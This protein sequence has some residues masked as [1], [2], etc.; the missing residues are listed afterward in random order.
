MEPILQSVVRE[1][2]GAGQWTRD[3]DQMMGAIAREVEEQLAAVTKE[4]EQRTAERDEANGWTKVM[5]D[6][7]RLAE[8]NDKI[9]RA[10]W[11]EAEEKARDLAAKLADA[12]ACAEA[13][14]ASWRRE[15]D[16]LRAEIASLKERLA[17][18][19]AQCYRLTDAFNANESENDK[20]KAALGEARELLR[21]VAERLDWELDGFARDR[22]VAVKAC[23]EAFDYLARPAPES[24]QKPAEQRRTEALAFFASAPTFPAGMLAIPGVHM[25]GSNHSQV[26]DSP[27]ESGDHMRA[28]QAKQERKCSHCEK[29]H[30]SRLACPEYAAKQEPAPEW[31]KT[32]G[33][34]GFWREHTSACHPD[35]GC[36]SDCPEQIQCPDCHGAGRAEESPESKL[37]TPAATESGPI[38]DTQGRDSCGI[39]G[40]PLVAGVS[41]S[42]SPDHCPHFV[43]CRRGEFHEGKAALTKLQCTECNKVFWERDAKPSPDLVTVSRELFSETV[44]TLHTA[45]SALLRHNYRSTAA[46]VHDVLARLEAA[47][48]EAQWGGAGHG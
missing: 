45:A 5:G 40:Q 1:L 12:R 6:G 28:E 32:C 33:G 18:S 36:V 14:D 8:E 42:S 30:D 13:G 43:V 16:G 29:T 35:G 48:S 34:D 17:A 21:R 39:S 24:E 20:L 7:L 25:N 31:C 11:R 38:P 41:S 10:A 19:E 46:Q 44:V 3:C 4:L 37:D 2:V 22:D 23:R 9:S 26:R 47:E 27:A 15:A